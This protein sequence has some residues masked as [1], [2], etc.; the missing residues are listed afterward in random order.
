MFTASHRTPQPPPLQN[1]PLFLL[2]KV[3]STGIFRI[4]GP[5]KGCVE[6]HSILRNQKEADR[7]ICPVPFCGFAIVHD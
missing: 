7:M 3:N 4:S 2:E 6:T 5:V 1:I